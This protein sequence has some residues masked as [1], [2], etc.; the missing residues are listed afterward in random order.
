MPGVLED[1]DV[2]YPGKTLYHHKA[3]LAGADRPYGWRD[4]GARITPKKHWK[5]MLREA[6]Y[7]GRTII[8]SGFLDDIKPEI[9]AGWSMTSAASSG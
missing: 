1:Y 3:I 7:P 4:N 9:G 6:D 8:S 2:R 5:K